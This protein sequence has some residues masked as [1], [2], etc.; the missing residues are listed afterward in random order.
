MTIEHTLESKSP[1]LDTV[2][3]E[4]E[5]SENTEEAVRA[6][7]RRV[8]EAYE[9]TMTKKD[10]LSA[11]YQVDSEQFEDEVEEAVEEYLDDDPDFQ[12]FLKAYREERKYGA[13]DSF[14]PEMKDR[15]AKARELII[16]TLNLPESSNI[17]GAEES[18]ANIE[19][20]LKDVPKQP[21]NLNLALSILGAKVEVDGKEGEYVYSY[22][23]DLLPEKANNKWSEYLDTVETHIALSKTVTPETRDSLTTAD[24]MRKLAHDSITNIVHSI[25]QL[26]QF[27]VTEKQTR[28]ILAKMRNDELNLPRKKHKSVHEKTP[29]EVAAAKSL[30]QRSYHH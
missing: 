12:I 4:D 27:G 26:E 3:L 1:A 8:F 28:E 24:L 13:G 23:Y 5:A 2:E 29:E 6:F 21:E 19:D 11:L 20:L 18:K 10:R 25:L 17:D 22:P 14:V 30:A 9:K 7:A 15:R 16:K